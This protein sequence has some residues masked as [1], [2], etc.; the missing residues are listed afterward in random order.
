MQRVSVSLG[1]AV[2]KKTRPWRRLVILSVL[3]GA[4][5]AI[6]AHGVVRVLGVDPE[7]AGWIWGAMFGG[8]FVIIASRVKQ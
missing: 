8:V 6:A 2:T 4:L 7:H 5:C 3:A 1:Y